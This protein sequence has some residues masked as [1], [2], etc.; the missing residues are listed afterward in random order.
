[1]VALASGLTFTELGKAGMPEPV[2]LILFGT[3]LAAMAAAARR[4]VEQN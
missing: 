4:K 1:M 3:G 2:S